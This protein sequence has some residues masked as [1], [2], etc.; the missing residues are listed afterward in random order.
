MFAERESRSAPNAGLQL[1]S[2]PIPRAYT[3]P[4]GGASS[5]IARS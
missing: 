4:P 1:P 2:T 3:L 5:G